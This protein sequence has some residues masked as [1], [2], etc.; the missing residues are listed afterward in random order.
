ML[1]TALCYNFAGLAVN[2][3]FLGFMES[4]TGSVFVVVTSNWWTRPEQAF[5]TAIWLGGTPIGNSIGGGILSYALGTSES[6]PGDVSL[7]P[8][9][10]PPIALWKIFFIFFGSFSIVFSIILIILMPDHQG[11]ARWLKP[12]QRQIAIERVRANQT[13]SS[14]HVWSWPQFWEALKDPQTAMFFIVAIGNTMPSTFASQFSS[15]I[16]KGFGFTSL[17]TTVIS[18]CPAATIQLSTFLVFSYIAGRIPS[19]RL[20]LSLPMLRAASHWRIASG[21]SSSDQHR[22][23]TCRLLPDLI[24]ELN[25]VNTAFPR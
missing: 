18:T 8:V 15:Q 5:R 9:S 23:T 7:K 13:V 21:N 4:I 19:I 12:R 11:N 22:W 17:Q 20:W 14:N 2:R 16:V 10:N 1:I 3:F 24:R 6:G 25:V